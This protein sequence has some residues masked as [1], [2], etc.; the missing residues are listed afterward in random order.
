M[1]WSAPTIALPPSLTGWED[2]KVGYRWTAVS[3]G[4]PAIEIAVLEMREHKVEARR[5]G[6]VEIPGQAEAGDPVYLGCTPLRLEAVQ[7]GQAKPGEVVPTI[8]LRCSL[9]PFSASVRPIEDGR[10]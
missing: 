5:Y 7:G 3:G 10:S 8:G 1:P 9:T 6:S 4:S 2:L